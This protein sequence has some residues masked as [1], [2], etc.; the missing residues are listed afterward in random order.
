[1]DALGGLIAHAAT[2]HNAASTTQFFASLITLGL[3]YR[4][5]VRLITGGC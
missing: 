1:M 4:G 5:F 2:R 3:L